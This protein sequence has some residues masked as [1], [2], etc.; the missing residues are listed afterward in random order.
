MLNYYK[1]I[2][3]IPKTWIKKLKTQPNENE[4]DEISLFKTLAENEQ[5]NIC[6]YITF[7]IKHCTNTEKPKSQTK[8]E[9][10][11]PEKKA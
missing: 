1:M 2:T 9:A 3:S 7:Q 8:W 10:V 6:R 5:S 11:F 4:S